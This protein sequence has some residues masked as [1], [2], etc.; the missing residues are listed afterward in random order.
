MKYENK[1]IRE[2]LK[3]AR[4]EDHL[5]T[6]I[7]EKEILYESL[8]EVTGFSREKINAIAEGVR[9]RESR[10]RKVRLLALVGILFFA[11]W[12]GSLTYFAK[13]NNPQLESW[14]G[15]WSI[16]MTAG[17]K[18]EVYTEYKPVWHNGDLLPEQN[19]NR[20]L[21]TAPGV[22]AGMLEL[23]PLTES[24]P[25][26]LRFQGQVTEAAPV[27]IVMA[28]GNVNG[29]CRLSCMANDS[30]VGS[31]I[32][33]GQQW[34]ACEF[35]LSSFLEAELDLQIW[36]E[37]GGVATWSSEHGYIDDI[38]F[39]KE[40]TFYTSDNLLENPGNEAPLV[41]EQIPGWKVVQG[42]W[43]KRGSSPAAHSGEFYF[44]A[45]KSK[46][47]EL[48]QRVSLEDLQGETGFE[49][50]T[51]VRSYFEG[52]ETQVIIELLNAENVIRTYD[53][54]R[55]EAKEGWQRILFKDWLPKNVTA[56]NVRLISKRVKGL[57]NDGYFDSCSLRLFGRTE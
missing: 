21:F 17:P 18:G 33:N 12:V 56:V 46:Y 29:D 3:V 44:F 35:D 24:E 32:L 47:A 16:L 13:R 9:H 38:Y 10:K 50:R 48:E 53:S 23:H 8:N 25:A 19:D 42:K 55:Y 1:I 51:N 57:N 41:D 14:C 52:D 11:G 49:F 27:L 37:A 5:A 34:H 7:N 15:Q 22:H 28:G 43:G 20:P 54:G 31:Y 6:S 45:G 40:G 2:A 30:L 39:Q 36:I 4:E 26:K